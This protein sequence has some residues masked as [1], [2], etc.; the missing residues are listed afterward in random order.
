MQ[1]LDLSYDLTDNN[2]I[3][4][5]GLYNH[6][7]TISSRLLSGEFRRKDIEYPSVYETHVQN[8][9]ERSLI[10]AQVVSENNFPNLNN[11]KL[12]VSG[13]LTGSNQDQPDLRFLATT[14]SVATNTFILDPSSYATTNSLYSIFE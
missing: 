13:F 3:S 8:Y 14:R 7:T 6:N 11:A 10:N 1:W 5:L 2:R 12:T 9:L 4:F